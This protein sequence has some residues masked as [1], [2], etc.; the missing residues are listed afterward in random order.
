MANCARYCAPIPAGLQRHTSNSKTKTE[1]IRSAAVGRFEQSASGDLGGLHLA[2][3]D[4]V[5][6]LDILL[7]G[8]L[9][10][11]AAYVAERVLTANELKAYVDKQQTGAE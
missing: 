10:E 11:D 3:G 1:C 8:R 9:W 7:T 5:Q 2:R 4:F 6:A